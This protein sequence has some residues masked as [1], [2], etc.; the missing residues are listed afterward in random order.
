[1]PFKRLGHLIEHFGL[2]LDDVVVEC[3]LK[4]TAW[5]VDFGGPGPTVHLTAGVT[6]RD[7]SSS[8][9]SSLRRKRRWYL[10]VPCGRVR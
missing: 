6:S 9:T 7:S 3:E 4:V 5:I 10:L 8:M 1:M 2:D